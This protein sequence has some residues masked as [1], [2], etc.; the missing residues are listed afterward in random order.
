MP[1]TKRRTTTSTAVK[2]RYIDKTYTQ[3][4]VRLRNE[5]ASEILEFI[6]SKGWSKAEFI[7]AAYA[8]LKGEAK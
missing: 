5:D 6:E 8:A 3:F 2:Q 4:N 7:K 1:D